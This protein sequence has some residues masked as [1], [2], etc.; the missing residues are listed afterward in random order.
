ML[1]EVIDAMDYAVYNK[2]DME[3]L[4]DAVGKRIAELVGSEYAMVSAGAT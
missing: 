4:H 1:P 2:A 3:E